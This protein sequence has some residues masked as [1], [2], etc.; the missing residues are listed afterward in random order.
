ME[1]FPNR[2]HDGAFQTIKERL[3]FYELIKD[4]IKELGS[5]PPSELGEIKPTKTYT[6]MIK[7]T[8][9]HCNCTIRTTQMWLNEYK[10]T[11]WRCPCNIGHFIRS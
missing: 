10:D 3:N 4:I 1:L 7:L 11:P 9:G 5:Y 6:R 8:C 2:R